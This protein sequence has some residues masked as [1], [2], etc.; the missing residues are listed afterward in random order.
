MPLQISIFRS[1]R[2]YANDFMIESIDRPIK[3]EKL[4]NGPFEFVRI[5]RW[6]IVNGFGSNFGHIWHFWKFLIDLIEKYDKHRYDIRVKSKGRR[7]I[8]FGSLIQGVLPGRNKCNQMMACAEQRHLN[9]Q[10]VDGFFFS[11][12]EANRT[13]IYTYKAVNVPDNSEWSVTLR[14][15]LHWHRFGACMECRM[16]CEWHSIDILRHDPIPWIWSTLQ[17]IWQTIHMQCPYSFG[18]CHLCHLCHLNS[19]N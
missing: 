8:L 13:Q 19:S 10:N 5:H 7:S 3:L 12:A 17:M 4:T 16:R 18:L 14:C 2:I 11:V 6:H 9:V 15:G 1:A